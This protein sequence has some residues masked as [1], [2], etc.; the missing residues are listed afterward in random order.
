MK[1][2]FPMLLLAFPSDA[3]SYADAK[4]VYGKEQPKMVNAGTY[5]VK[6]KVEREGCTPPPPIR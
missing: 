3:I 4:G 2:F 5:Q 1:K 6:Y